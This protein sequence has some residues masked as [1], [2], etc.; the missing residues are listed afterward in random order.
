[1]VSEDCSCKGL[2]KKKKRRIIRGK[3]GR[4]EG[5]TVVGRR[6]EIM[7]VVGGGGKKR[8]SKSKINVTG[9]M[10]ERVKGGQEFLRGGTQ[11]LEESSLEQQKIAPSGG[12]SRVPH[13]GKGGPPRSTKS[14]AAGGSIEERGYREK[15]AGTGANGNHAF[16]RPK[17]L[18]RC[19]GG[20]V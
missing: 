15:R 5:D 20:L 19:R 18:R 3:L 14:F 1:L 13:P 4:V 9:N 7:T 12:G 2:E 8:N 10:G 17:W 16:P 11:F 6:E